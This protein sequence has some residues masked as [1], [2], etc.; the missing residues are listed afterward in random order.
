MPGARAAGA[1]AVILGA[2]AAAG[3]RATPTTRVHVYAPFKGGALA[4]DLVVRARTRGSCWT[5]SLASFGRRDAWRCFEGRSEIADPCFGSP[6]RRNAF[7][8]CPSHAWRRG[9]VVVT[10]TKPLPVESVGGRSGGRV[11]A[12]VTTTGEHCLRTTGTTDLVAGTPLLFGWCRAGSLAGEPDTGR[13]LW[14]VLLRRGRAGDAAR[15]SRRRR[16][17][18][19]SAGCR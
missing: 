2:S 10:L 14:T 4:P 8:V 19:M 7:V 5:H 6:R 15:P 11:W 12:I 17:L 3:A 1:V 9:V 16:G 18:A 13:R